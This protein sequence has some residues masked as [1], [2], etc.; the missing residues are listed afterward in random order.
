MSDTFD[1]KPKNN[2]TLDIKPVNSQ[3]YD[4]KPKANINDPAFNEY[5]TITSVREAGSWMG[6]PF[7]TYGEAGTVSITRAKGG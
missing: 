1:I 5:E 7:I 6:N 2:Q 3:A 4:A